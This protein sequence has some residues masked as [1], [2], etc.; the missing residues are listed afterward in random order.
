MKRRAF[1]GTIQ[2]AA[3]SVTAAL[4]FAAA[5]ATADHVRELLG[6][7]QWTEALVEAR[8]LV[9]EAPNPAASTAL[10]EALYRAGLID[11]AGEV[12]APLAAAN[13]APARALAQLGLVRVAQGKDGE[14]V[15]LMERAVAAAPRDP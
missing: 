12:L 4:V 8:A 5:P 14:A 2:V 11:D 3:A 15:T 13:D 6:K 9:A 1:V 7:D 10:G